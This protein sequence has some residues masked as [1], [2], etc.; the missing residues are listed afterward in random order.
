MNSI[1]FK[2]LGLIAIIVLIMTVVTIAFNLSAQKKM[3]SRFAAQNARVLSETIHNSIISAMESGRNSEIIR[4]FEQIEEE[5]AIDAVKIFDPAGRIMISTKSAETGDL[6]PSSQLLAFR[7]NKLIFSEILDESEFLTSLTPIPNMESCHQCHGTEKELLGILNVR[8]SLKILEELQQSGSNTTISSSVGMFLLMFLALSIFIIIY[9]ERPLRNIIL[10]MDRVEKGQF[11]NAKTNLTG[12]T[13]MEQLS[14]RFNNMVKRLQGLIETT[15]ESER[16]LA[17]SQEKLTHHEEI[18][19][20]NLTLEERLKEIEFLNISMEERIEEIEE[21]N[22]RIADLASELEDKNATLEKTVERLSALYKMGLATN[23]IMEIKQLFDLLLQ[24]TMATIE[25][26]FGYILLLDRE[27]W[28]LNVVGVRGLPNDDEILNKTIPLEPGGISHWVV[29]NS[30]PLLIKN[31]KESSEFNTGSLL[32][33]SRE[34]VICAPLIIKDEIIGTITMSNKTDG[35]AFSSDD[36]TLLN[37]IAAQASV[38]I[39]NSRLYDEQQK[40]YLNTVHALVTAIEASDTYTRGH[41]ERVTRFSLAL[42]RKMGLDS[43]AMVRLEHAAILH[44]I[45]KIGI[46]LPLLHKQEKLDNSDI[47]E[48]RQ[49]PAIGARILQPVAF[50]KESRKI[51][52]QHHERYDGQGYPNSIPGD[53]ILI[54]SRIIAVADTYDAMTSDRP[55]R[56]AL[57]HEITINE[58]QS[59][60]G[61]QFD[62][63]VTAHFIELCNDEHWFHTNITEPMNNSEV[64]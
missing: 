44:D 54:E 38:G 33:F 29:V 6:I 36:L 3:L 40:T 12:S 27:S 41:S 50:L 53:E 13:E 4:V 35:T 51:V 34:S 10:S 23:S 28:S 2:L 42:G 64:F 55:Y 61:T 9:I 63:N 43:D 11:K 32:G 7:S 19:H 57:S 26:D 31:V 39:N 59:C 25:A 21:A 47:E 62:P 30:E 22:F 1:K 48:L 17:I 45:G 20:M 18:E 16:A 56:N 49:H 37:T 15:I 24:K 46:S 52:L 8:L 58:I 60:S 14:S 5:S